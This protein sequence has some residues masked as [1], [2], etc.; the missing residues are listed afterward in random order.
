[1]AQRGS[2]RARNWQECGMGSMEMDAEGSSNLERQIV[3]WTDQIALDRSVCL[4]GRLVEASACV[5]RS[6]RQ[7]QRLMRTSFLVNGGAYALLAAFERSPP[8]C[9]SLLLKDLFGYVGIRSDQSFW[10][11]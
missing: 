1:M 8:F 3:H 10:I 4:L 7:S 6:D 9:F 11:G 5:W 2:W